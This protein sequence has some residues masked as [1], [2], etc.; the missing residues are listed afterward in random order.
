MQKL[1]EF[2]IK[3]T[4]IKPIQDVIFCIQVPIKHQYFCCITY[5]LV[6]LRPCIYTLS[7][8]FLVIKKSIWCLCYT[9]SIIWADNLPNNITDRFTTMIYTLHFYNL[10]QMLGGTQTHRYHWVR[11]QPCSGAL[12]WHRLG[13]NIIITRQLIFNYI[14]IVHRHHHHHAV[15]IWRISNISVAISIQ[16]YIVIILKFI[17]LSLHRH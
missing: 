17:L 16:L 5:F 9:W 2:H 7:F 6:V 10:Q 8:V 14:V 15:S 12:V 3:P 4:K 13:W 11:G 1:L